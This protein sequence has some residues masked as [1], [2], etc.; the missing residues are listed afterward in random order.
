M[1]SDQLAHFQSHV[2]GSLGDGDEAQHEIERRLVRATID[3]E[4]TALDD[5][6]YGGDIS[7][8]VFRRL[9]YDIDLAESRLLL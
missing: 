2:D 1:Y 9:Q 4:R 8:E 6:R 3:A 5:L 7:D